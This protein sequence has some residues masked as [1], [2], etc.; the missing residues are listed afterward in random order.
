MTHF[1]HSTE[2]LKYSRVRTKVM[3][4]VK[5]V[6]LKGKTKR[7][8]VLIRVFSWNEF[9]FSL[10]QYPW[11]YHNDFDSKLQPYSY[12][13]PIIWLINI[14][15]IHNRGTKIEFAFPHY[16]MAILKW[17]I[18]KG[19]R[20]QIQ[21]ICAKLVKSLKRVDKRELVLVKQIDVDVFYHKP[22]ID[23]W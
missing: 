17:D 21:L 1:V 13:N 8:N 7:M 10:A 6:R 15:F 11:K 3:C 9:Y 19:F 5:L 16:V 4:F 2:F 20:N 23:I 12:G 14:I 18:Y 22:F